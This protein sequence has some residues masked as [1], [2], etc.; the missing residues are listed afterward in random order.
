MKILFLTYLFL[1]SSFVRSE[2]LVTEFLASNSGVSLQDE[3]EDS[4]DWIEIHNSG[5]D[6]VSLNGYQL[7]DD[8]SDLGQ[9][10][11]PDVT[12]PADGYL[13]V[14]ASS[15]NRAVA[16]GE[17]HTNFKLSAGGEY[18][19]LVDPLGAIVDEYSPEFPEQE[20][21]VSYGL[22]T[23]EVTFG[24]FVE[25]TPGLANTVS[26]AGRVEDTQFSMGRG[27]YETS[28]AVEIT[29]ATSGATIRYTMDGSA[30][31]EGIDGNGIEYSGPITISETTVLRAAAF[32]TGFFPSNVDTQSYLFPADVR[33][34]YADGSAPP[35]WPT[36]TVNDQVYDYGMDP[37]IT[38]RYTAQEMEDALTAI[39]SV[40]LTTDR[41][42]LT[43]ATDG[44]YS[45]ATEKGRDWERV[46]H[47]EMF[48]GNLAV[49]VNSR[50]GLRIRGGASRAGSNPKHAF[51][52]FF[53]SDYG[54][55]N[56]EYPLFD[57]EGVDEFDKI[58]FRTA[59]NYSWSKDGDNQNTFLRDVLGRDLQG[60]MG[61]PYTRSRYVHL[62][63]NGIYWGLFMTQERAEANWGASYL[64]GDADDLDVIKA[65]GAFEPTRYDTE[66]TDGDLNGAWRDLW[67]LAKAQLANPTT[68]RYN[69]MQGLDANGQRDPAVPVLLDVDN[70]I[71]YILLLGFIGGYDNSLST[72]V[73]ASNNW[74]SVR[75]SEGERGFAHI[76]HDGEHS[77]GAG[78]GRWRANNDRIN[79]TNGASS[80]PDFDKSNP[81][82]LHMDLAD[83]T[84][85]YRLRF[86]DRAHAVLFNDGLMTKERMLALLESRSQVV[87]QVIIA[88]SARWG[89][90]DDGRTNDPADKE[91]WE[92]EVGRLRS[93]FSSRT[94]D[95]LGHLQAGGLYPDVE[96]P[97]FS[98]FTDQVLLG[99]SIGI[100]AP[101]GT[102]YFTTD[103]SDPRLPDGSPNSTASILTADG[104]TVVNN[105]TTLNARVL[106]NGEWSALTSNYYS[107]G[108]TPLPGDLV[109]SEV[110]YHPSNPS[111]A[112]E[113]AVSSDDGDFEFIELTNIS[114]KDLEL[115]GVRLAEQVID[116]HLEGVRYTFEAGFILAPG[117]RITVV[118]NR[119]AFVARYPGV[120]ASGIGGEFEGGLG[121]SGEWLE[122]QNGEGT[123]IA[124]FRYNDKAP[125]PTEADGDGQSL[126][127]AR[128]FGGVEYSDPL[129]WIAL[130]DNGSPSDPG[131]GLFI[132]ATGADLDG[133]G[134]PSLQEYFA[135][136]TDNDGL[137]PQSEELSPAPD[138]DGEEIYFSFTRDPEAIGVSGSIQQSEELVSWGAPPLGSSL[139]S[140]V[141]LPGNLVRETYQLPSGATNFPRLFVRLSITLA[142]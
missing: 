81:Q 47:L 56:L 80:R 134:V 50:C 52:A 138:L 26:A 2:L 119:A 129:S 73:G 120:A 17:L 102:I 65:T 15:K 11:F 39:P 122:L 21:D 43:N 63:L 66:A 83:S 6:P 104:E 76:L 128:L 93:V 96:A 59:Q 40:M 72:F 64:G 135:G 117:A 82:F 67:D 87:D 142:N 23:D 5:T 140:R 86:A 71:D 124:S 62:Y 41:E 85:E 131:P 31:T 141:A 32:K 44:I 54:N 68:A 70:L 9:W 107:T 24:Y 79:T 97:T 137:V 18:L 125:W 90:A 38:S 42:N 57:T 136:T 25:P 7:T 35:G 116:D 74:F 112:A 3:D 127:L 133:D 20:E 130:V 113:L 8:E 106:D 109:I 92:S 33:T 139:V 95:F 91:N 28:F 101:S 16:G 34:Q 98:P 14:F 108:S 60:A 27:I 115:R 100:L 77:L 45:N 13:V 94:E 53:R 121:N 49:P 110:H 51:R 10:G 30:P 105:S 132:G 29:S 58:D 99:S 118:A 12:I 75:N 19:A 84:P 126:Q 88:E 4:S 46:G 123:V 55:G 37:D 114:Q 1:C 111:T 22:G 69:Q 78:G 48:G 61:Q 103:G 36:G 89:D